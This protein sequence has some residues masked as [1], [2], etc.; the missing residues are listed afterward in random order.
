MS[1]YVFVPKIMSASEEIKNPLLWMAFLKYWK[2]SEVK[3][4][5]K[6]KQGKKDMETIMNQLLPS[7]SR[8]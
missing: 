3:N 8:N 2:A 6:Q 1:T 7:A 4:M 5:P